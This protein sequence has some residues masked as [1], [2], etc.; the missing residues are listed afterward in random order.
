MTPRIVR[1]SAPFGERG[2]ALFKYIRRSLSAQLLCGVIVSVLAAGAVF[3][4]CYG[5][6]SIL[7]SRTIYG[8]H[9]TDRMAQNQFE[10]LQD[11]VNSESITQ[12]TLD[13]LN[14]WCDREDRIYFTIYLGDKLLY[15]SL[16]TGRKT[17]SFNSFHPFFENP[18]KEH[19]LILSDGT[20]TQV[21]LYYHVGQALRYWM[22]VPSAGAA[23][24][25]FSICFAYLVHKKL[26]YVKKLKWELD[27]LSG[28]DLD[29][30]V[31]VTGEDEMGELASGIDQMR[32]SILA[33]QH[34]EE[35]MRSANS[36]LVTAMSHDLRTPLTS[37]LA[38]L[39]MLNQGKYTSQ[40]QMQHFI[41]K[42]LEQTLRIKSMADK[43]FEYFLV[44]S[45]EWEE[46]EMEP[47][48]GDALMRQ[49]WGEYAFSLKG[50]GFTVQTDFGQLDGEINVNTDM[51][52]RAF[53]NLYSNL[54]KYAAPEKPVE[55]SFHREDK[56]A[57]VSISNA[58]R[59][60]R[61]S[62][63]STNIGLNT[64]QRIIQ[65]H[66][67]TFATQKKKGLFH[68]EIQLPLVEKSTA[69]Q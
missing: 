14:V 41:E 44:Y 58:I 53:D 54:L 68:V 60:L 8:K 55:I 27:I 31:T 35:Q 57:V 69:A 37:L 4:C 18:D 16:S 5:G 47:V 34:A 40:A 51:L 23:F 66:G 52:H 48:D 24:T 65:Y 20:Y 49:F 43:L 25:V 38:Y 17:S 7:L 39:E 42:S 12:S 56:Q 19:T 61:S 1:P 36:Q 9:F 11:F 10:S 50:Q 21:Y 13:Q 64:C 2:I 3:G 22:M 26:S 59:D 32:C 29:Y 28:G 30:P 45:S 63:E 46:P 33:H 6:G 15:E 62:R 67:G